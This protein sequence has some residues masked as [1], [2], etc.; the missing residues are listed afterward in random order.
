MS[1]EEETLRCTDCGTCEE[2]ET[3]CSVM[4]EAVAAPPCECS[5]VRR[6][7]TY[8]IRL[9]CYTPDTNCDA[10]RDIEKINDLKAQAMERVKGDCD[11]VCLNRGT[12]PDAKDCRRDGFSPVAGTW[13]W[14]NDRDCVAE[15]KNRKEKQNTTKSCYVNANAVCTCRCENGV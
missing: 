13:A 7:L 10:F 15:D 6:A 14:P 9:G 4:D 12:C 8:S 5:K 2:E 3:L 1:L 11:V